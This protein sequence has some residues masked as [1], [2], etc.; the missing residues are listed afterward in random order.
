MDDAWTV[1]GSR[2]Y[3]KCAASPQHWRMAKTFKCRKHFQRKQ[4]W[5][6]KVDRWIR[7]TT[8]NDLHEKLL[9]KIY[10]HKF[11]IENIKKHS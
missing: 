9:S 10:M 3:R 6:Y 8:D 5:K 2:N 7:S 4:I 11:P 1:K